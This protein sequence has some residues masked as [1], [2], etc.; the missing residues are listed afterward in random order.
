MKKTFLPAALALTLLSGTA[1]AN[2]GNVKVE[3]LG[4]P[5]CSAQPPAPSRTAGHFF[6]ALEGTVKVANGDV[7]TDPYAPWPALAGHSPYSVV[8]G[9]G[10]SYPQ[11]GLA[12]YSFA[13]P[14]NSFSA[15]LGTLAPGIE[16]IKLS[17][18]VNGQE[19]PGSVDIPVKLI[20]RQLGQPEFTGAYVRISLRNGAT[21]NRIAF[22]EK[23]DSSTFEYVLNPM[24][25]N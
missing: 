15:V 9:I 12:V 21:W 8:S 25:P 5:T 16:S 19:Q 14:Q 1:L 6:L 22:V 20:L 2:S 24:C 4:M 10:N 18:V 7:A 13:E 3:N 23:V 17:T 11:H